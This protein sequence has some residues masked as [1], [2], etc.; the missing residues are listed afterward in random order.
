MKL[1]LF[2]TLWGDQRD[3]QD[4]IPE[5][6]EA[7]FTG[8]EARI[9]GEASVC[10]EKAL[11][12]QNEGIPYIAIALTGGGVIPRQSATMDEHLDDLRDALRRADVMHPHFINVLGGNDRWSAA[13]QAD[14]I[15]AAHEIG[16]DHGCKCVFETHRSR[17]LFSPWITLDVLRQCPD[18]EFTADISHWVV[19]CER[20]LNDPFDNFDAF[21]NRVHHVQARTGYD[22]GP[23]TPHPGAPEYKDALNFHQD[24]W[25]SIWES[26]RRRGYTVT[27]M[28]PEFGPDGYLHTLPFTNAPVADLWEL[29]RWIG[30]EEKRLFDVWSQEKQEA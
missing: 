3:W 6:R 25:K 16:R 20:L 30:T 29:N 27:T 12:L 21:I 18:A 24:F 14:F 5:I 4:I 15:N 23:Q 19:V 10:K 9:P 28:T 8:I 13:Q 2:R 26:Q 1:E 22:Q 17:I 7:G 11:V